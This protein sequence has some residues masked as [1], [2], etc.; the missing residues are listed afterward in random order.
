MRIGNFSLAGLV[1][2]SLFLA[3]CNNKTEDSGA[4]TEAGASPSEQLAVEQETIEESRGEWETPLPNGF[5]LPFENYN[6]IRDVTVD[7]ANGGQQRRLVIEVADSSLDQVASDLDQSL[8]AAGYRAGK[9]T[10]SDGERRV[11][12][13]RDGQVELVATVGPSQDNPEAVS[14]RIGWNL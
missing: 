12:Y 11:N 10:E 9:L 2:I 1:F 3:A 6:V 4:S 8:V 13:R 5:V 7:L 14:V